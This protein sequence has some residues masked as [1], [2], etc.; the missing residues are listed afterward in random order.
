[1]TSSFGNLIGTERDRLPK[2]PID[3]YASTEPN[4]EEAV[5]KQIDKNIAD[6][7]KFFEQ[8]GEIEALKS[9]NFFDNLSGLEQLVG[10]VAKYKEVSEK[11]KQAQEDVKIGKVF[12]KNALGKVE[13]LQQRFKDMNDA[14]IDVE[15][16][17]LAEQGD[18]VAGELLKIRNIPNAEDI[19]FDTFKSKFN[20]LS[21]SGFNSQITKNDLYNK[22]TYAEA[23]GIADETINFIAAKFYMDLDA[24][25]IDRNS[26]TARR[27]FL[28]EL[29]PNLLKEKE[30]A[31]GVWKRQSVNNYNRNVTIDIDSKIKDTVNSQTTSIVNGKEVTTYD[32]IYDDDEAG[33]LQYIMKKKGL[34]KNEALNYFIQRLPELRY[35]LTSGG[36]QHFINEAQLTHSATG[37]TT[38]GYINSK[39]GGKGE[40]E[41][42]VGYIN[43]IMS[44]L[45]QTSQ[46]V[47]TNIDKKYSEEIREVKQLGLSENDL[48]LAIAEKEANYRKELKAAGID[49]D[50]P[51][52]NDFLTDETSGVG[53]ESY[54]NR[55][56][57][58]FDF[59]KDLAKDYANKLR[60]QARNPA[61]E[62]TTD[63][64]NSEVAAANYELAQAIEKRMAGDANLS[65]QDAKSL[66]YNNIL[67]KLVEGGYK[68][69]ID[70]TRPTL[71][72]D[73]RNDQNY[74]KSNGISATM[75][76]QGFVSLDE[77]RALDKLYDYY[78]SG[79][80]LPFPEYFRRVTAGTKVTPH[81][82]ALAR[83][84]ATFPGDAS[85]MKNPEDFFN[86][87]DEEKRFLYLRKNQT[88]NL[89]L[90]NGDDDLT[91]ETE[92]L[93][94]LKVTDNSS[95]Y[96]DPNSNPFTKPKVKL[97]EMTV[98]DA[99]RKAKAGASDFGMY[100]ISAE[101]LIEVVEAG[102]IRVDSVMDED[103]QKQ[104]V[105]GLMRIQANKSNSI[106]GALI[107]ADK[108]WRRLTN[109]TVS[110]RTQV[111]QF[112]PNLRG[113]KN[114]QF[115]NLQGDINEI[116][117]DNVQTPKSN[118]Y[119]DA[120][121]KDYVDND[122]VGITI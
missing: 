70:I 119:L 21:V 81:E 80:A 12:Q 86:L 2:L 16:R 65:M 104:F 53:N 64:L 117:L 10:S 85:N 73:I 106:M 60:E 63:Q 113:M 28:K 56:G 61:I 121:I 109:L 68:P 25:G 34:K 78:E 96:R 54:S 110:E 45:V 111:H 32:G 90:L 9:Q 115:H 100:K 95:Y 74:L 11:Y 66:E 41:G 79:F 76:Q 1:M 92:V 49:F 108:D 116:I 42:N 39:I 77:K 58:N 102:G 46:Q 22:A 13:E 99:Y 101:E 55:I 118:K 52:P 83:Y 120:L 23:D 97:E 50:G 98:A 89:Q 43:R 26:R 72:I 35:S 91:K 107:D 103:T 48:K 62:L 30:N 3:N 67:A 40:I 14:D 20:T 31:L 71:A 5:N 51:L 57:K 112:F 75:N 114:N 88:K 7:N 18:T 93:N 69:K 38:K 29:I 17:K 122:F 44:E 33:L 36:L 19:T 6:Q 105:F 8:L 94:I 82:Y 87:K 37:V 84:K 27:Y 59:S 24:A 47:K 4:L 15:L